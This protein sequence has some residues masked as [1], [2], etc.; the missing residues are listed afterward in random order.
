MRQ[1]V[2][3]ASIYLNPANRARSNSSSRNTCK[4]TLKPQ[5]E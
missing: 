5:T 2:F 4:E 1:D 3:V